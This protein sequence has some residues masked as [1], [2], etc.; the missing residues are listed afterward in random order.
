MKK[1]MSVSERYRYD[2]GRIIDQET[3]EIL[4]GRKILLQLNKQDILIKHKDKHITALTEQ[5]QKELDNSSGE[6]RDALIRIANT[7]L[8]L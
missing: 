8:D 5:F 4:H 3:G 1:N 7:E 6:L 2:T